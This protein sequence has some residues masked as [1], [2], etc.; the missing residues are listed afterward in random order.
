MTRD[1][2]ALAIL[3][4][5]LYSRLAEVRVLMVGSGGIGCELLKNIVLTGFGHITLLDLDTIDLSNLNRQFLFRKKDVKQPKSFVAAR[6]A[7]P[8]NPRVQIEPLHA[9]IKDPQFDVAWFKTF[10]IVLNALDNLDARRH[11]NK[12]CM[13]ANVPLVESGT[14]GYFGQVQPIVKDYTE[15]FDCLPKPTPKTFPVCTI[16]STPS[17][18]IHCIVWAKSYLFPYDSQLFGEGD[19]D[20]SELDEALKQGENAKEIQTLRQEAQALK[21]VREALRTNQADCRQDAARKAFDKVFNQD[22]QNLLSMPDMWR[23][24]TKPTPLN[25]QDIVGGQGR[26]DSENGNGH[27]LQ[28]SNGS[29]HG[30]INGNGIKDRKTLSV[31]DM[32]DM[33]M[34]S[35]VRLADRLSH[36]EET[37][38]FDKD[39]NDT[40]DFVCAA[41]NLRSV[42]YNIPNKTRWEIK[43]MA[44]NIIPAI[45]TTNAIIAG[46]IVLQALHLLRDTLPST[47][48]APT[49]LTSSLP[50]LLRSIHIQHKPTIP[51]QPT[52]PEPPNSQCGVC[53]DTYIDMRCNVGKVT[54][55]N[56]VEAVL[57]RVS[58]KKDNEEDGDGESDSNEEL[59][60]TV[61][62]DKRI[63][64]DP[65]F[66]DN[67][68]RTLEDLGCGRGKFLTLVDEDGTAGWGTI[69]IAIGELPSDHPAHIPQIVFQE[70]IPNFAKESPAPQIQPST[71]VVG[72]KRPLPDDDIEEQPTS[73][74]SKITTNGVVLPT[75]T[76]SPSKNYKEVNGVIFLEDESEDIVVLDD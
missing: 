7:A 53:R 11:V 6:T 59:Y 58:G 57:E 46:L 26:T 33:F 14:A 41:A 61:Y 1:T 28:H 10:D 22:V 32:L 67:L 42:V 12:M 48:K 15:C 68:N 19:D 24:R 8:F 64:A 38:S 18:P 37:I 27:V 60:V 5:E 65:D 9:N 66:D 35:T 52:R 45:A 40:L 76:Q 30:V 39:D 49:S 29:G 47:S 72:N 2:H 44:G 71:P 34:S 31:K 13:A 69:A 51:L 63:L 17:Q 16:R 55:R 73:K 54:L 74:R 3:G 25:W 62:E 20:Q 43:E 21:V 56:V 36:G 23:E 50:P 75:P 4:S 70:P